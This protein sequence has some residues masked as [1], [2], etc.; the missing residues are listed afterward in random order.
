MAEATTTQLRRMRK[1]VEAM[2][3]EGHRSGQVISLLEDL[4]GAA[5][6]GSEMALFAHR[7]LAELCLEGSPW[8]AALHLRRLLR[9]G[10][11]DDGVHALLG[12]CHALL[13][14]FRSAVSAYRGALRMAP[15][16][17]WY[18]HNLGHL[19]DVGLSQPGAALAHL[20][21]AH[22]LGPGEDEV[23]ASLAHCLA[24][25]GQFDEAAVLARCAREAAP[26]NPEHDALLEWIERGA[27]EGQAPPSQSP[28]A[29][30]VPPH[31]ASGVV[32]PAWPAGGTNPS[33]SPTPDH[34]DREARPLEE[35]QDEVT[36]LLA[37]SM[38]NCGCSPDELNLA[39]AVWRDF[40]RACRPRIAKAAV[41]AAAV[42]YA[43]AKVVGTAGVTQ[44]ELAARY[45][46]GSRSVSQRYGE[47]RDVLGLIPHDP[48]YGSE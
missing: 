8:K 24:R 3:V 16:N 13:G 5:D 17:P 2:L 21:K 31:R 4:A 47:I 6:E 7:Q 10:A 41:F 12:L 25:L 44:A 19:L 9:S 22:D 40:R 45:G 30:P 27:P 26:L 39:K 36:A 38:G 46:V 37:D 29:H 15:N 28:R 48:R 18:H 23:T 1:R 11:G 35:G 20:R 43:A 32:P 42:E 33:P 14:N 34:D